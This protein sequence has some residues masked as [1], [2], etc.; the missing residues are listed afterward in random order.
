MLRRRDQLVLGKVGELLLARRRRVVQHRRIEHGALRKGVGQ[1]AALLRS[2]VG[3]Q[4]D[5]VQRANVVV[6]RGVATV[7]RDVVVDGLQL[8]EDLLVLRQH[9]SRRQ[10]GR[11]GGSTQW[12]QQ[13][14]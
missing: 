7:E 5:E 8:T 11:R 13:L 4:R 12:D 9:L 1:Q 14:Q 3:D 6:E 10:L 2:L